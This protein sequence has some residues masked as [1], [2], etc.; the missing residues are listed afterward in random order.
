VDARSGKKEGTRPAQVGR[1]AACA[2]VAGTASHGLN[3][4][5][6]GWAERQQWQ[7]A[8]D[9]YIAPRP[10]VLGRREREAARERRR[11]FAL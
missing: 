3:W 9:R 8:V 4:I 1:C 10:P 2:P 5:L 7:K 11:G 6:N